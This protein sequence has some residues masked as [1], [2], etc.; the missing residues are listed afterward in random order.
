[1]K[2]E[3]DALTVGAWMSL[4]F[5][6]QQEGVLHHPLIPFTNTKDKPPAGQS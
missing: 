3:L 1:M 4:S 6:L 2:E 5:L